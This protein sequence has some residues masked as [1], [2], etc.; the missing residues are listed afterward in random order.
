[1]PWSLCL[2]LG[3]NSP[4]RLFSSLYQRDDS[5]LQA[6]R[7]GQPLPFSGRCW[8]PSSWDEAEPQAGGL[9]WR[10]DLWGWGPLSLACFCPG[11][12]SALHHRRAQ[13]TPKV[14]A[15]AGPQTLACA[16]CV[17]LHPREGCPGSPALSSL[18]VG[19]PFHRA[20]GSGPRRRYPS[21][22]CRSVLS[23]CLAEGLFWV[24][25]SW[26]SWC[27]SGKDSWSTAGTHLFLWSVRYYWGSGLENMYCGT[28]V[29]KIVMSDNCAFILLKG[30]NPL[31][32]S[33][34]F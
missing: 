2:L 26:A 30:K 10:R 27:L 5:G 13:P 7:A 29:V 31:L 24:L 33:L 19:C 1:V 22:L 21:S 34:S 14:S 11:K 23:G 18:C 32:Q 16:C 4:A 3:L 9:T 20:V 12:G 8:L 15:P 6:G 17:P 28:R 25:S